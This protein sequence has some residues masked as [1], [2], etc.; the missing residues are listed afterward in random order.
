MVTVSGAGSTWNSGGFL[1]VGDYGNGMLN[2]TGGGA[3]NSAY[4]Y[5][6]YWSGVPGVMTVS[7]TGSTWN[8][9]YALL[10]GNS[11]SGT[12]TITGGGVVNNGGLGT[13]GN[14][15]GSTGMVIVSGTGSTWNNSG[16][17][18]VGQRRQW[19]AEH[20]WRRLRQRFL[21]RLHRL[22]SGSTGAV[23]VAGAGSTWNNGGSLHRRRARQWDAEHFHRCRRQQ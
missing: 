21:R 23:T 1:Y 4:G 17:L 18:F 16:N 2:I 7:G 6:G 10:V 20:H 19:D 14:S 9:S 13:I 11:G 5:I 15:P 22:F 3:V 8:N 12:L